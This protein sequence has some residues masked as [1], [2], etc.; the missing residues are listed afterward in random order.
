MKTLTINVFLS[1]L[2][3]LAMAQVPAAES[4]LT[5]EKIMEPNQIFVIKRGQQA[6]NLY[7]LDALSACLAPDYRGDQ[8]VHPNRAFQKSE[9]VL[10]NWSTI[11]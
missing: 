9:Q 8:P 3:G 1:C 2:T 7:D 4:S 11:F 10:K 6:W 5:N